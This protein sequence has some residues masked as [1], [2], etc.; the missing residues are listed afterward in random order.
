MFQNCNVEFVR[1]L[2]IRLF[3]ESFVNEYGIAVIL[4]EHYL[5]KLCLVLGGTMLMM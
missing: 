3:G 5:I 1:I 2:L 4:L